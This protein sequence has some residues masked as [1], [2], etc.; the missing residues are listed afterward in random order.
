MMPV[1]TATA[2]PSSGL[3]ETLRADCEQLIRAYGALTGYRETDSPAWIAHHA[4]QNASAWQT[5][6]DQPLPQ[7]ILSLAADLFGY[8]P[9]GAEHTLRFLTPLARNLSQLYRHVQSASPDSSRQT[10]AH[11]SFQLIMS[12]GDGR[13]EA[14]AA[15]ARQFQETAR[16]EQA[17]PA[18]AEAFQQVAEAS[19]AI[20]A[21]LCALA[22]EHGFRRGL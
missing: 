6:S 9:E 22:A 12:Q 11:R 10:P 3:L 17:S 21:G 8:D 18:Y 16:F 15:M 14:M 1:M 5:T 20:H 19:A 7:G 2:S 4:G 13:F